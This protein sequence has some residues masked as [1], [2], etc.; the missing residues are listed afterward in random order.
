M[1]STTKIPFLDLTTP[2]VELEQA[3]DLIGRGKRSGYLL[4]SRVSDVDE[5]PAP[6]FGAPM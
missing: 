4:K 5:L 6:L 3:M 2:H 1:E